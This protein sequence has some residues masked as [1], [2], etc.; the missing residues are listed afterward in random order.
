MFIKINNNEIN[1][2]AL[3]R[4][5]TLIEI[6]DHKNFSNLPSFLRCFRILN[7]YLNTE[8]LSS[9]LLT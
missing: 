3:F 1:K 7:E 2:I 4:D 6:L 8:V 5:L 9:C